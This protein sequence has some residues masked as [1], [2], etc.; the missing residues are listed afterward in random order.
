MK[1]IGPFESIMSATVLDG[2]KIGRVIEEELNHR[3]INLQGKAIIPHLAVVIVGDD[4]ASHVYVSNKEM[5]CERC[6]IKSTRIDL[7][8][9]ISEKEILDT[10]HMLNSDNSV[11]GILVQSPLPE[12]INE[13]LVTDAISPQKDVDGFHK[14]NLGRLVQGDSSGLLP[15]TPAGIMKILESSD[16]DLSGKNALVIG[17]SRIV[18]MPMSILLAQRGIDATVTIA[19][20]R[21]KNLQDICREA[22]L[23]VAA[24]GRPEFVKSEW[25]K[26]G[27]TVIDVGINRVKDSS[28][29]SGYRLVGDVDSDASN[30]AGNITPVPGGVGPMTIA[31]LMSNTIMA[32]ENQSK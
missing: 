13:S 11:H 18:G 5:A 28:R 7:D 2:K 25:I 22:D 9:D 31:M 15:C 23:V 27:A 10:V 21:T 32:T 3:I 12:G 14:M 29:K 24:I 8:G 16:I 30:V 26:P 19:H 20:S 1:C 17:R 6:G 4:P